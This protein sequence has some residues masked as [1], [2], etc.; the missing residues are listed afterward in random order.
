MHYLD[1]AGAPQGPVTADE[2]RAMVAAGSLSASALV[3]EEGAPQ[4]TPLHQALGLEAA[5]PAPAAAPPPE[6][7]HAPFTDDDGTRYT[8]D[9]ARRA[10]VP[11]SMEGAAAGAAAPPPD[12]DEEQVMP[13][14]EPLPLPPP[15]RV[16]AAAMVVEEEDD[17][18]EE[19]ED[20]IEA[21]LRALL[22]EASA[23]AAAAAASGLPLPPPSSR[24]GPSAALKRSR[25]EAIARET[26]R[27]AA[28]KEKKAQGGAGKAGEGKPQAV[29]PNTSVYVTGIPDDAT[30]AEVA[31][32]FSKCGLLRV[33]E[34]G[35]PRV[36]LYRDAASGLLKGDGLVT[37]L[38]EPS[39]ALACSILDGAPLR[40]EEGGALSVT[41]ATFQ[42]KPAG[43]GG[44]GGGGGDAKGGRGGGGDKA[45]EKKKKGG[46]GGGAVPEKALGWDG[47]DDVVDPKKAVLVL[48][49]LFSPEELV[50]PAATPAAAAELQ[51]DLQGECE[52]F[53]GVASVR[54][55][56]FHPE[57][58]ATVKFKE[59]EAA[60]A[61]RLRMHGRWFGGR[62]LRA[63]L[64]D[65]KED[66]NA[67]RPGGGR[68]RESEAEEAA[69][70][71]RYARELEEGQC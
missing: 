23:A 17:D 12:F 4:W 15:R 21:E 62:Q 69:R 2:L 61:C 66:F 25:E 49:G 44:K 37:Y 47:F 50:A 27:V 8:W 40:P 46:R 20:D 36:K 59:P 6:E 65:G 51:A 18:E 34:G 10:F 22:D 41:P 60:E 56:P 64:Y 26:E 45:R 29:Q 3:W 58:V 52:R 14:E 42:P 53:G 19:A 67:T 68:A 63:A 39:V 43:G 7:E 28:K 54:L 31:A 24:P 70:L 71:D 33:G 55:F 13:E 5:A 38:K 9:A 48:R 57:G 32:V 16:V 1:A 35:F 11:E 30:E